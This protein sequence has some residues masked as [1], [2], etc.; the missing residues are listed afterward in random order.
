[1]I[2]ELIHYGYYGDFKPSVLNE[3]CL[4]SWKKYM[5]GCKLMF[6]N[7]DNSPKY[8]TPI[9]NHN[10]L[11][12]WCLSKF[13]GVFMDNDVQLLK[14]LDLNQDAFI[15]F[16]R[17]DQEKECINTA[18]L[19]CKKHYWL[20]LVCGARLDACRDIPCPIWAGCGLPQE[21]IFSGIKVNLNQDQTIGSLRIYPKTHSILGDGMKPPIRQES[22]HRHSRFTT[23]RDLG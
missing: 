22:R 11:K 4:A 12:Y 9:L 21:V 19:A 1:M 17:D 23:G 10:Y 7:Q 15:G 2:P 14:P 13:G 5:P 3:E 6:W 16:Q 18:I 20:P 8:H